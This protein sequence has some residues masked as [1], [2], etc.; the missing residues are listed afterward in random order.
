MRYKLVAFDLDGTLVEEKSS[1][2]FLHRH[3]GAPVEEAYR[4]LEL[5][6]KGEIDYIEFMRRDISL[7]GKPHISEIERAFGAIGIKPFVSNAVREIKDRG[8]SVA[9][10]TGGIDLLAKRVAAE[11]GIEHVFAN[12]LEIDVKGYLTGEGILRVE[13]RLKHLVLLRLAEEL[14]VSPQECVAVGDSKYDVS[15]LEHAGLGIAIGDDPELS[16]VA[17]IRVPNF[18]PF[19]RLL[20]F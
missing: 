10:I 3:F 1:W 4:N 6:E 7:W 19:I 5:Y 17:D 15:F 2:E 13:P 8:L 18:E 12:G 20:E 9:I 11:L 14:G 16:R